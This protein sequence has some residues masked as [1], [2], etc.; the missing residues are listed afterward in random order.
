MR[1]IFHLSD[2]PELLAQY[3]V[4]RAPEP[5][6]WVVAA[7]CCGRRVIA[8]AVADVR[9]VPNTVVS[10]AGVYPARDHDWLCDGCRSRLFCCDIPMRALPNGGL[11]AWTESGLLEARGAP[12]QM[13]HQHRTLEWEAEMRFQSFKRS[14]EHRPMDAL[15]LAQHQIESIHLRHVTETLP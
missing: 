14:E 7:P 10:G 5:D 6:D 8:C 2:Y 15:A 9:M 4:Q 11:I 13:V 1:T 3:V 12:V